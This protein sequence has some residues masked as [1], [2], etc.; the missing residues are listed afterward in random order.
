MDNKKINP[1]QPEHNKK[2]ALSN[3]ENTPIQKID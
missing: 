3:P 1:V 2:D